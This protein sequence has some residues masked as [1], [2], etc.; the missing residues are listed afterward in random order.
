MKAGAFPLPTNPFAIIFLVSERLYISEVAKALDRRQNTIRGWEREN[1]LPKALRSHKD[2]RGWRY[3]TPEQVE[4]IKQWIV[5]EDRRP[6]KG[7]SHYKPTPEQIKKHI[8]NTR[9]K[10]TEGI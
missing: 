5:D 8:E 9:K 4:A 10:Q 3:W 2:D 7:F 6:G 1:V